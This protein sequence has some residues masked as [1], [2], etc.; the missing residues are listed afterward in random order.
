MEALSRSALASR[1][2][3][4]TWSPARGSRSTATKQ[5]RREVVRHDDQR[6]VR[7]LGVARAARVHACRDGSDRRV[8]EAGLACARR[9]VRPRVGERAACA[10]RPR[11]EVGVNDA[12]WPGRCL[13]P[14]RRRPDGPRHDPHGR[15]GLR[16][17]RRGHP[18]CAIAKLPGHCDA[19]VSHRAPHAGTGGAP[20]TVPGRAVDGISVEN[21]VPRVGIEPTTRGFSVRCSTN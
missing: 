15:H 20:G 18:A 9:L 3:R 4:T 2:T 14:D 11:Q 10:Q 21:L 1:S 7:A 8:L 5:P 13:E 17:A 19:G 12:M 16:Q 6:A